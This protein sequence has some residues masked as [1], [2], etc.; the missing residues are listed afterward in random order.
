MP[1]IQSISSRRVLNSHVEF[2]TEFSL[3][4][5]D[6]TVGW[7]ASSQGETTS[8][9]EDRRIRISPESIVALLKREGCLGVKLEQADW[10]G[11]L[12]RH[13]ERIGRNNAYSLSLAF[14]NA[15]RAGDSGHDLLNGYQVRPQAL[16]RLCCNIL[17]GGRHAYTNP[18]LSDF[19]EFLLVAT[20][21]RVEEVIEGHNE[22]QRRVRE[23]LNQLPTASV[24]GNRVHRFRT[25]DNREC[26]DFLSQI[27]EEAGLTDRFDLMI[28][29]SAGDLWAK[30]QYRFELTDRIRFSS[31]RFQDYWRVLIRDY[32]VKFLEDPFREQDELTWQ[33]LS[34]SVK[35]V[36]VIGDN[37]YCSEP[38]RIRRG[39]ANGC[40]HGVIIK[41]NQAGTITTVCRAIMAARECG[42]QIITSHRSI[43]TE[44]TFLS[45]LTYAYAAEYIKI[46]P[47]FTDYS[48]VLRLNALLRL[49]APAFNGIRNYDQHHKARPHRV[50]R[51]AAL[52]RPA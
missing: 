33:Q 37:F 11:C 50:Q 16:P 8:V 14:Y 26:L 20:S 1:V 35:G 40:T 21:N 36:C 48:S 4:M 44:E 6:G 32:G 51:P 41:P 45:E 30:G 12:H 2:T 42:Q 15:S 7:G 46:G 19:P 38:E 34:A 52:C 28:D 49:A 18:V 39:A 17:N 10:D 24:C 27:R 25:A 9:F 13:L 5:T 47:L 29:A 43:S 22:I 3:Q 31:E 23:K